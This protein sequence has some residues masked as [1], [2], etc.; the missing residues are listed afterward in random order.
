MVKK[1]TYNAKSYPS[2]V[3]PADL[4][5]K[6]IDIVMSIPKIPYLKATGAILHFSRWNKKTRHSRLN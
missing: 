2:T 4:P 1:I 6:N 3:I 5:G